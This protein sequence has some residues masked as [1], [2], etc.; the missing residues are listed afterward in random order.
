MHSFNST[1]SILFKKYYNKTASQQEIRELFELL[2]SS[3]D[4]EL[5]ELMRKEWE[6][7]ENEDPIFSLEMS[8]NILK[9]ILSAVED[10]KA[11]TEDSVFIRNFTWPIFYKSLSAAAAIFILLGIG[12][13]FR[14]SLNPNPG[15]QIA[16]VQINQDALP[17]VNKAIL[18]LGNGQK[19]I[20]DS[21]SNGPIA[22][23]ENFE[24]NK[25]EN[26]Q[27]VYH[28]FDKN[29]KNAR[30]EDINTLVTPRGGEYRITLPDGS[31]VWLN[32]TSSI[33]FPGVFKGNIR[34]VELK[35]EAYFEIAKN[36][37]MP[38]RVRSNGAQIEVIGTHFNVKA[39]G[40]EKRM[41]TTLVEGSIKITAGNF[42]HLL[43]PGQQAILTKGELKVL[44]NVDIEEQV[45]WKN[46]LFIFKDAT[47]EE[48]MSQ[49]ASW[50]DLNVS[51]EGKIPEKLLTGKVSRSVNSTEFMNLLNYAGV[52]FKITGKN[53]VITN[54]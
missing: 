12:L 35:G 8:E 19:I 5:T 34:E 15:T 44:D 13:Y 37:A 47:I 22:K 41:K 36:S 14:S 25:T 23:T 43:K 4:D 46:G 33:K 1:I 17:G 40:N 52:K 51:F 3:S 38:F 11:Q 31:K 20:L 53:I 45:A 28:A 29:H 24:V 21:L 50:Y 10:E 18:I 9:N 27:L 26:G 6:D 2:K 30:T 39:Y 49:V 42:S 7:Q 32:A 48:V 16:S 54:K